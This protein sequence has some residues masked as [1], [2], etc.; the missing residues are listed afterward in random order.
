MSASLYI[1]TSPLLPSWDFRV[2]VSFSLQFQ[3]V[4]TTSEHQLAHQ[5]GTLQSLSYSVSKFLQHQNTSPVSVT[6]SASF[7]IRTPLQSLSQCQKLFRAPLQSLS[8]CQQVFREP[9]QSLSQ[10]QQVF[11]APAGFYN[12]K[13]L[14]SLCHSI[15]KFLHQN[16]SSLCHSVSRF[17]T[18]DHH[19]VPLSQCQQVFTIAEHHSSL[20]HGVGKFLHQNTTSPLG[21]VSLSPMYFSKLV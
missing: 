11:R 5:H 21:L 15:R 17:F 18:S 7:Y 14:Q 16:T 9:L 13:P 3:Q 20:C 19:S 12:R 10:C 1:G 6:V 2:S 8:Q 4:F